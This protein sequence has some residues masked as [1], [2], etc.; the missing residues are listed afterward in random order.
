MT[1][2]SVLLGIALFI[3]VGLYLAYP[4]WGASQWG[5]RERKNQRDLL[6]EQ[7]EALLAQIQTLDFDHETGKIPTEVHTV[8]RAHLLT[9]A[10][11]VLK[12]LDA[13][14]DAVPD[15][16]IEAA[17]ARTRRKAAVRP[18]PVSAAAPTTDEEVEAAIA[19]IRQRKTAVNGRT[20]FC[21]QCG[22]R[23][24]SNDKFCAVCGHKLTPVTTAT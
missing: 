9:E 5:R 18:S 17:I 22:A 4:F 6:F 1:A 23:V 14:A 13:L 8:Q 16:D 21:P 2:G 20:N 11:A 10:A 19:H 3:A 12:Q 7:K 15:E 24:S